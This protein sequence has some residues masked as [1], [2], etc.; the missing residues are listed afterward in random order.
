MTRFIAG[1]LVCALAGI[2]NA[3]D[4]TA[5]NGGPAPN[6]DGFETWTVFVTSDVAFTAIDFEASGTF[7]QVELF[8]GALSTVFTD[9]NALIPGN[10]AFLP[11]DDTQ[12]LFNEENDIQAIFGSEGESTSSLSL[13]G[14][15][16]VAEQSAN[17]PIP[18]AQL[19]I[20][21]GGIATVSG[22]I[23]AS[24]QTIPFAGVIGIPE[25]TSFALVGMGIVGVISRRRRA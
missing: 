22:A 19:V 4:V 16:L 21:V 15:V 11:A 18:I 3:A 8:G 7:H 2:A 6:V 12:F 5:T 14:G 10:S 17:T 23:G 13:I 1:T 20:P 25:P 9:N 24:G